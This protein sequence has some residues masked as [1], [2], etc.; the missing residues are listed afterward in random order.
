MSEPAS[1]ETPA[2]APRPR[3]LGRVLAVLEPLSV[4]VLFIIL[5]EKTWLR[6]CDP[7]IDFPRDL[8]FAWRI[9]A[10]DVLYAQLGHWYGP[11]A[12]LVE[13]AGEK[14]FGVGLD[15]LVWMNIGVTVAI[16]LLLRGISGE[17][18][19]RL[20]VWL[21]SVSFLAMFAFGHYGVMGNY[22]FI[23]PYSATAIYGLGGLVLMLWGLLKQLR[24]RRL[25]WLAVAGLG[26]AIVYLDK[27]ECLL[28]AAGALLVYLVAQA[29]TAARR[30]GN[31]ADWRVAAR[32]TRQSLGWF[33]GGFL[34][35]W[36]PVFS[37]FFF[38]GGWTFAFLSTD[39]TLLSLFD[40]AVRT[41]IAHSALMQAGEGL[42][43]PWAN[44]ITGLWL[45]ARFSMLCAAMVWA[46]KKWREAPPASLR[47]WLYPL[48]AITAAAIAGRYFCEYASVGLELAFPVWG[49]ALAGS[50]WS[51]WLAW[52]RAPDLFR[53]L[54][55]TIV[56]VAAS[57]ML[58]R[59]I[60]FARVMHYGFFMMPLAVFFGI[61]LLAGASLRPGPGGWRRGLWPFLVA[62]LVLAGSV[63]LLRVSLS[64]YEMEN[65]AVGSGRDRFYTFPPEILDHGECLNAM[66]AAFK[67]KT[68]HAQTLAAFPEGIAAN[69]HLRVRSPLR[70]L[71]FNP[72]IL[73]FAGPAN[74]VAQLQAQPPEAVLLY[75]RSYADY[76]TPN[77]GVTEA[78]GRG[79]AQWLVD[80][81]TVV[82]AI[83]PTHDSLTG[84][85]I[86]LM[87]PN[88]VVPRTQAR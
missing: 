85:A 63:A 71:E 87:T 47:Y 77:F 79:I 59:M 24:T 78:T 43:K 58:T 81:D 57:L 82:D 64:Y 32:S 1:A 35:L 75:H 29:T 39:F 19:N 18:G 74:M 9:S 36:L 31:A 54:G 3:R 65:Y 41:T 34:T 27:F 48:M 44:F 40:A 26:F 86:I 23:T 12:P 66:I 73:Q 84:Y 20:T 8:Y 15:T 50:G 69:Y 6:W 38:H 10:G 37:Y 60:L 49:L 53:T 76:G 88:A 56:G 11:L 72:I 14:A 17:L 16:L 51:I 4:A 21:S 55:L 13:G 61:H 62:M 80:H 25:P 28:A 70:E 22:N 83:G 5:L 45:G 30:D 33:A 68:P 67:E 52:H 2:P 42:D 7:L 46:A